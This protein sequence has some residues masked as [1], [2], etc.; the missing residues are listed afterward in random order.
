MYPLLAIDSTLRIVFAIAVLFVVVPALC[1]TGAPACPGACPGDDRRGRLSYTFWFNFGWGIVI[2]TI[3]GQ[4][5]TLMKL[6]A[7]PTLLLLCALVILIARSV[8]QHRSPLALLADAHR[9][10]TVAIINILERRVSV[11][12][13]A[14]RIV[15]RARAA[16]HID[17]VTAGWIT[18]TLIAAAFRLYRPFA[19]ANLGYSDSYGHL[20]LVKLL[21]EG[22]QIDPAWGP[23]P[24]GM[25]FLLLAIQRLTNIDEIL[26]VNFFGAIVGILL[27]LAVA[28]TAR[29]LSDSN[30]AGLLSGLIFTTMVGG[31]TQYFLLGGSFES[32]D[33]AW[34]RSMTLLPY[35]NVPT[36]IG[37][38][39][40]LLTA[41]QRQSSTLS[42]ELAIVLLFPA[43]VFLW[44]WLR[45]C[46][47]ARL[48]GDTSEPRNPATSQPAFLGFIGCT[49]A[50]AAVHSGVLVP[51]VLL[52]AVAAIAAL[53]AHLATMRDVARGALAGLIGILLGSTWLLGF[54]AYPFV[55]AGTR[56]GSTALF[57]FPFLRSFAGDAAGGTS[58]Q[59][60][61][62]FNTI[63]PLLIVLAIV[64]IVMMIR[65]RVGTAIAGAIY[66]VFFLIHISSRL[67][68]P[69]LVE[70]RRNSE[71]FLMSIAIL[72]GIA[73]QMWKRPL[74]FAVLAVW[75]A[76][77]PLPAAL[78]DQLLNYSG[79]GSAS[80]AVVEIAHKY[81][82]YTWTLVSYGQEYPMVLGR[83]FHVAA[84]EFLDRYDPASPELGIPTRHVFVIT[85]RVPHR[86]EV[87]DWRSRFRRG[88]I[89]H[90]LETWC[91]LYQATHGDIRLF[92]DDGN[93]QVFQI[94][95]SQAEA[96][97]IAKEARVQ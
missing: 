28:W 19:T 97:R 56:P 77:V 17:A 21:D 30:I 75:L 55:A 42:Q 54:I 73:A 71:W 32:L 25:H 62:A 74:A 92:L 58:A 48:R 12:R 39:D 95:R 82:P 18:L 47:V 4:L 84:S 37:E 93:V 66:L 69:Q 33:L 65:G 14:R 2:L 16:I 87:L 90:R 51:L 49:A 94:S 1:G 60:I 35:A 89:E 78:K 72:I 23:Y 13:R 24:R 44:E 61:D 79:Y 96:N 59:Q 91:Q 81:E 46:A 26:L 80:L 45:G 9:W 5:L 43:M 83:G 6:Y 3:A 34:A 67:G 53:I 86:F 29:R 41:F 85:E 7:L 68:L 52:C 8:S 50:I 20:Y 57:Y 36:G 10:I 22:K 63:T 70:S 76:R 27:T 64:A 38:F 15:R 31:P 88:E 40:V 11:A